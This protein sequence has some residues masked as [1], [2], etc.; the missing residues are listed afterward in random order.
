M[1]VRY[2]VEL[3]KLDTIKSVGLMFRRLPV[4]G[5]M[6]RENSRAAMQQFFGQV[7]SAVPQKALQ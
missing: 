2:R 4:R 5:I 6:W 7:C 1:D 3:T